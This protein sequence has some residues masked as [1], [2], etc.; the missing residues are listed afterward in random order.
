MR[1]IKNNVGWGGWG[2]CRL[3]SL[4]REGSEVKCV[5]LHNN[6]FTK[7]KPP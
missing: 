2:G 5:L 1:C 3:V 6:K 7:S 4:G